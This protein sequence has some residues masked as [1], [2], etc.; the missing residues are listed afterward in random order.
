MECLHDNLDIMKGNPKSDKCYIYISLHLLSVPF[1]YHSL[2]TNLQTHI[3]L[4]IKYTA[5]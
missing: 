5:S 4:H 1:K 3:L 2:C